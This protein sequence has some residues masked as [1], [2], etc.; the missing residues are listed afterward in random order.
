VSD[1]KRDGL[2]KKRIGQSA[3]KRLGDKMKVQRLDKVCF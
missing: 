1:H 3:A 2:K